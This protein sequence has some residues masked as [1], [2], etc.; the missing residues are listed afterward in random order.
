MLP[1]G[2]HTTKTTIVSENLKHLLESRQAFESLGCRLQHVVCTTEAELVAACRDSFGIISSGEPF[3]AAVLGQ[4][5]QCRVLSRHG[6]GTDTIDLAA[7]TAA[8]ILVANVP[9][10]GVDEV[11]DHALALLLSLARKIPL[12][13]QTIGCGQWSLDRAAPMFRLR[14]RRL[15]LVGFGRI[16]RLLAEKA[17][18]LGLERVAFDPYADPDEAVRRGVR[19]VPF[20]ELCATSDFLSLHAPLT[21]QTRHMLDAVALARMKP[22][23]VVINTA[24]GALIDQQALVD[25]LQSGRIAGCALDVF[26]QEPLPGDHPLR[27]MPQAVLTPHAAYYSEEAMAELR[28]K[29]V[30]NVLDVLEGYFPASVVNAAVKQKVTLQQR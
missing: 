11:S 27:T 17:A 12:L 21:P 1:S 23:A 5:R 2:S 10:A 4:L 18:P 25:A 13:Q 15:G 28:H 8:G 6:I 9:D 20:E 24:R 19:L 7:A 14:G 26:E 22:T 30:R 29:V 16:A 3:T